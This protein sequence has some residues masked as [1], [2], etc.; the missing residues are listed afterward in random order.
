MF[1]TQVG[2]IECEL[3]AGDAH[4]VG[5]AGGE[6]DG[7]ADDGASRRVR[8][9]HARRGGVVGHNH[10]GDRRG[11]LIAGCVTRTRRDHVRSVGCRRAV[12]EHFVRRRR[13]FRPHGRTV[14]RE[15]H[16]GNTADIRG[17]GGERDRADDNGTCDRIGQRHVRRSRIRW[18][19]RRTADPVGAKDFVEIDAPIAEVEASWFHGSVI[20]ITASET[21]IDRRHE[22]RQQ[23]SSA[24]GQ[25]RA[26]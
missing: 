13:A 1:G 3:H 9:H 21:V 16:A 2:A 23:R 20:E 15:L 10:A 12:P 14:E 19:W 18:R 7:A 8:E 4:V 6:R 24:R 5:R 22:L 25:R 26:E 11:L 17:A